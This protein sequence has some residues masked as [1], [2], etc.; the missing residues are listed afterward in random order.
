[1]TAFLK[2]NPAAE[3]AA[4]FALLYYLNIQFNIINKQI[5]NYFPY[6]W[7][8]S[9]VHLAVGLLIMT[10]FW[11]TRLVKF[12][13]PDSEFM[14]DVTLPSFLHA[15]GHCLT[16]VSLAAVA[17]SFTHTI[18]TLEPVFSAAGAFLLILYF[19]A[20]DRCPR[21][22]KPSLSFFDL[23]RLLTPFLNNL[24]P[25]NPG[26][27]LVSGTVYAWPVYASLIPVIGGVALAS[28]T[29]LS[30][31]WLGFSCA[32]AS[33]VAFSARAI[34]SKKLMSRM[35]PLNLYNFVTIVSLMFCIPF[36][37]IFEGSTIM[38]GIQSAVALKGQKEFII[39]MLKCGAFYHLYNQVANQALGKVEPVTHAVGNV[40]KRIFVIGFSIIAFGNKI[41]PQTAVGSAI[42]VLGAGL[43]SY[44]KN[45]YADQTK[46]IKSD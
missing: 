28:A 7:F 17:V 37:F 15:F 41:S 5:Y 43:Y 3:T 23:L 9:A 20:F 4:Y 2:K 35:S 1:M 19:V 34:F 32:M 6:P 45:K 14:K 33:N 46:Q 44:V 39:A 38:A 31:T 40:G 25:P 30:F 42:A 21:A 13:T 12:E 36:V 8:V 24:T 27:Y 22:K 18:K 16:N 29:E 11:T 26:M 10:F